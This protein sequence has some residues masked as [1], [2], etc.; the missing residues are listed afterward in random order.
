MLQK[1]Y[2][3]GARK[4]IIPG[5]GTMGCIPNILAR[6]ADGRCSE[7]V[8][9]L[10]RDFNANVRTMIGNLNANLPGSRFTYVDIARMNEDILAN[11]RA[12]GTRSLPQLKMLAMRLTTNHGT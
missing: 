11:P 3:L 1:L 7:E 6:T 2:N 9:Q 5:I 8:N 10:V 4:F 12:Y